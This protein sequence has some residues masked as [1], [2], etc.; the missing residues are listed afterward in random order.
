VETAED[1]EKVEDCKLTSLL[2]NLD[3]E[4]LHA[5]NLKWPILIKGGPGTGKSILALHSAV[6]ILKDPQGHLEDPPKI[7]YTTYTKTLIESS[8]DLFKS[9]LGEIP[10]NLE[11]RTV[12]SLAFAVCKK[13][14]GNP[15]P[16][17]NCRP[18]IKNSLECLTPEE[19]NTIGKAGV[20]DYLIAEFDWIIDGWGLD[21]PGYLEIFRSGRVI[22]LNKRQRKIIWKVYSRY[23]ELL[24]QE[25]KV[26]FTQL[27]SIAYKIALKSKSEKDGALANYDFIFIDEAQDLP[28]V[29]LKFLVELCFNPKNI[30]LTAD[31]NQAIYGKGVSWASVLEGLRFTAHNTTTLTK[32]YRS[33][34]EILCA[35]NDLIDEEELADSDTARA[36]AVYSGLKP[37]F[38]IFNS[39]AE[40]RTT[41]AHWIRNTLKEIRLPLSCAAVLCRTKVKVKEYV[42]ALNENGISAIYHSDGSSLDD[43]KVKVMTVQSSKGLE[44]PVVVIP[45]FGQNDFGYMEPI[46]AETKVAITRKMYFVA[47]TRAMK[48]LMVCS[49]SQ[50]RLSALLNEENWDFK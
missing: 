21:E 18:I 27:S 36:E 35:A 8:K 39:D 31:M 15:N 50:N 33:T 25:N 19:R 32:N 46:D 49:L 38:Q 17:A 48:R 10:R 30:Y 47:C 1:L 28:P 26:S 13:H 16:L 12:T 14:G 9:Q 5:A 37:I 42:K 41:I 40:R 34:E 2:L 44:F 3:E 11:I 45:E 24:E 7:L 4:Q 6:S 20:L 43:A 23:K 22:G 29:T